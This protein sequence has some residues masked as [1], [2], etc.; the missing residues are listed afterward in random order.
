MSNHTILAFD[1]GGTTGLAVLHEGTVESDQLYGDSH[2][3][4]V[5]RLIESYEPDFVVYETFNW[6]PHRSRKVELV[7][8]EYIGV[9]KLVCEKLS[10]KC[11]AQ[12]PASALSFWDDD[13][14]K[15]LYLYNKGATHAND[16]TRH[17]L[18]FV[19]K[20]LD[21]SWLYALKKD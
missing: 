20:N 16:A 4:E 15:R 8:V 9:I 17:L 6:R 1:P 11:I 14:L 13:K 19:V 2:H 18:Q 12:A 5:E 21:D 10:I 3:I 7:S